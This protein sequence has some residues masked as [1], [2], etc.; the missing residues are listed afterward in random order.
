M[1]S[2]EKKIRLVNIRRPKETCEPFSLRLKLLEEG[3]VEHTE[4]KEPQPVLHLQPVSAWKHLTDEG[5]EMVPAIFLH[6]ETVLFQV[7]E[8]LR[9]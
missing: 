6:R 5:G 3:S 4:E 2:S 9:K 1:T 8:K 7:F